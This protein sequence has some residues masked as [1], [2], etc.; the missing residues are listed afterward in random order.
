MLPIVPPVRPPPATEPGVRALVRC[1]RENALGIWPQRAYDEEVY[2]R[3][4]FNRTLLLTSR[5]ED[6]RRVL[7]DAPAAYDRS[8]ATYRILRPMFGRGLFLATGAAWKRQRQML[9][10][11][12]TPRTTG[13][14]AQTVAQVTD[15]RIAAM[16]AALTASA[17]RTLE[18]DLLAEMQTLA[19]EV[20]GRTLFS[21]E[22]ATNGP[23]IRHLLGRYLSRSAT[24][25]LL[26][27]VAPA[28]LP[29][30]WD[31]IR[32]HAGRRW[33]RLIDGL[34]R[35]RLAR[36]G[37]SGREDAPSD[38]PLDLLD[39]LLAVRHPDTGAGLAVAELRD[40][41]AT[42][43]LAGHETTALT[44]FWSLY[45]AALAP[46]WQEAVAAEVADCALGPAEAEA[47]LG[48][49]AL[50]TAF[51]QEIL[52]LYPPAY[53][54]ARVPRQ[55][56]RLAGRRVTPDT[57]VMIAPWVVHRHRAFWD[58]PDHFDPRRFL[59]P[60]PM[61]DRFRYLPFGL[62]PRVCIG[63]RFATTEAVLVLA[64]MLQRFRVSVPDAAPV[65]PTAVITTQPERVPIFRLEPRTP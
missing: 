1:F 26:D 29:L 53:V 57:I 6:I 9:A 34:V 46:D 4:F 27:F 35:D 24:P 63:S 15:E 36:R 3:S 62:G 20:A 51:V 19:L 43:L 59:P 47:S 37:C 49:L 17:D 64:K 52:R 12:F 44:L 60:A 30:P 11:A 38:R 13:L 50:T 23:R 33:F 31:V 8:A 2:V 14:V 55:S 40:E 7:L 25:G 48:A 41:V 45:V 21:F 28:W 54:I 61:P 22:M 65:R 16:T 10:P 39:Q 18:T 32:G 56:D 42:L 58:R 5:A